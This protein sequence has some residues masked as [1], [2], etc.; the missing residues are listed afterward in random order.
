[1]SRAAVTAINRLLNCFIALRTV[2]ETQEINPKY[3]APKLPYMYT[4]LK[5]WRV[6]L[7]AYDRNIRWSTHGHTLI[8]VIGMHEHVPLCTVTRDSSGL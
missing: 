8:E 7:K 1:M 6:E 4:T 2:T 3:R 5:Q